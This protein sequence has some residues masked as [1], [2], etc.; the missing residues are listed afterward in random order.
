MSRFKSR[1]AIYKIYK[2]DL[3]NIL[4]YGPNAPRCYQSLI[5]PSNKVARI[6]LWSEGNPRGL[7]QSGVVRHDKFW[8]GVAKPLIESEKFQSVVAHFSE[9]L[10]WE[11]TYSYQ[12]LIERVEAGH[13]FEGCRS[14]A[15]VL[16]RYEMLDRIFEE[17][18]CNGRLRP[19]HEI[20]PHHF[21]AHGAVSIHIGEH[22]EPIFGGSGLHRLAICFVLGIDVPAVVGCVYRPAIP[23]YARLRE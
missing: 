3:L 21:R 23:T 10:P 7:N 9:G 1:R 16:Q 20:D 18:R 13:I 5:I 4:R 2:R 17:A 19:M 14:T 6:I 12:E 15:E 11:K 8:A 22:G